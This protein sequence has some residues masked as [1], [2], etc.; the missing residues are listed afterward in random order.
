MRLCKCVI[1]LFFITY[2]A[3][4]KIANQM[5][6]QT[7]LNRFYQVDAFTKEAFKGNP[8]GVV[9]LSDLTDTAYLQHLA[10]EINLSETAF[11]S[12][13]NEELHIRFFTPYSEIAL[14]GHA[15]LAA[16]FVL[17]QNKMALIG[18]PIIF[19]TSRH[20]LVIQ[21]DANGV[22]MQFPTYNLTPVNAIDAFCDI[23]GLMAPKE[24]YKA[25]HGWYM[26]Y[27]ASMVDVIKCHPHI[28]HMKHTD[29]GLL[30]ITAPG[31]KKEGYDYVQRCFVPALGIDEDPVTGSAQ[32][33]LAPFWSEK[34]RKTEMTAL[35]LSKRTGLMKVRILS[36]D[37]IEI[38]GHAVTIFEGTLKI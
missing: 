4:P 35:Q 7:L 18:E 6:I 19:K 23:T 8:A 14:C 30:I 21:S 17:Y 37:K 38:S 33:V 27:Y 1:V 5:N 28:A 9:V 26:A 12:Q 36:D 10:A 16:A 20:T 32:C 13:Q 24:L 15:T 11:I 31:N 34:L 29:F 2:L 22:H 25:E 3:T